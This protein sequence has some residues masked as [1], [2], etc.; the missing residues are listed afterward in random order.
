VISQ[1]LFGFGGAGA[2]KEGS[3][4]GGKSDFGKL[5]ARAVGVED[6]C[7]AYV[8]VILVVET[9]C[10]GLGYALPFIVACA[11]T[12]GVDVAPATSIS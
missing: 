2:G 9:V 10:Q 4:E 8:D 11:R 3:G 7:D 12:D 1:C 6:A 5:T